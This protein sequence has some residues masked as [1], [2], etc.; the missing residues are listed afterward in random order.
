MP[1]SLG[2]GVAVA[3]KYGEEFRVLDVPFGGVGGRPVEGSTDS[4]WLKVK[5]SRGLRNM[6]AAHSISD[7][8]TCR[9]MET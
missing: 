9:A 7:F 4:P 1:A 5:L 6:I 8:L 3:P 2:V